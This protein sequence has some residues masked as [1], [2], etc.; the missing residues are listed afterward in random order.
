MFCAQARK[1]P[2][3]TGK[4]DTML[5]NS[6]RVTKANANKTASKTFALLFMPGWFKASSCLWAT[7]ARDT[8]SMAK[9]A[10]IITASGAN[11]VLAPADFE[12]ALFDC[13]AFSQLV[14][15]TLSGAWDTAI[16]DRLSKR[17]SP[18]ASPE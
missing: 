12:A 4:P 5:A 17:A 16:R 15:I 18:T 3:S 10:K 8:N 14:T 11:G 2:M 1:A 7:L 6:K 13:A 9:T